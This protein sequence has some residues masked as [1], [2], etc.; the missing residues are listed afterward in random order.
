MTAN[1][2]AQIPFDS[3]LT[4]DPNIDYNRIE[5]IL[6]SSYDSIMKNVYLLIVS[7]KSHK[8]HPKEQSLDNTRAT[9]RD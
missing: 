3:C 9:K 2:L 5:N 1:K 6:V 7:K 8:I 4:T